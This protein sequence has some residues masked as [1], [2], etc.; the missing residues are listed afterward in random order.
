MNEH[1]I[2]KG[3]EVWVLQ[4]LLKTSI[5]MGIVASRLLLA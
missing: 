3:L 1:D 4:N 2:A 5:L